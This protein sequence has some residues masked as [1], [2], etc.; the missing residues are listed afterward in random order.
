MTSADPRMR[1]GAS[2]TRRA[3][4]TDPVGLA[5]Q[6]STL[7]AVAMS[8][9]TEQIG[10]VLGGRYRLLSP[11]GSGA[12]AQ[13][14]LAD[15]VRLRRR[16]AVKVLH[17]AL[18]DDES[19][20]RRF[21]AE[22][23]SAAAL[24]HPHLLAV[25]DWSDDDDEHSVPR[26]RVPGRRQP[27]RAARRRA[28]PDRRPRRWSWA[29][30]PPGRST[31]PTGR[32]S[33]TATSSPPTCCSAPTAGCGSPT[34]AWPGPSPRPA[35]PSRPARCSARPATPRPSRP[36]ARRSTAAA[37]CTRWRSCWS[38]RSRARC[39]SRPTPRSAR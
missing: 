24:S 19:F 10:R 6:A 32:A 21:R 15:D 31:T 5:A 37:T 11:L 35:G 16:V 29:S 23:Q 13:V 36:G 22:A 14:Y 4:A 12:S 17:P 9:M 25:Y 27:A 33:S 34:S 8:R 38:R 30:R 2:G 26:H 18:A 20:L 3:A 28:P 1:V 39:R 7:C